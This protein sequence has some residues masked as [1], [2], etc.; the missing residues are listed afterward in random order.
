MGS[1][2]RSKMGN[3]SLKQSAQGKYKTRRHKLW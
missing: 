1:K 2:M 3:V